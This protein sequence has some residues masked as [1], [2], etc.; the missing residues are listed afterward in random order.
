MSMLRII[1]SLFICLSIIFSST[2]GASIKC[3]HLIEVSETQLI[4]MNKDMPCH[5][6]SG[7]DYHKKEYGKCDNCQSCIT[8]NAIISNNES[9]VINSSR[10]KHNDNVNN[11]LSFHSK[12]IYSPPK[13]IS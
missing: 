4:D 6:N 5:K 11:F 12:T 9:F 3:C 7:K 2:A 13:Q 10:F 8:A 1:T